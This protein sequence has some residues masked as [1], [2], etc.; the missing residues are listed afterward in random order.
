MVF[1]VLGVFLRVLRVFFYFE[2]FD[3]FMDI[4]FFLYLFEVWII[5]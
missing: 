3:I 4:I 5:I 2:D 1:M